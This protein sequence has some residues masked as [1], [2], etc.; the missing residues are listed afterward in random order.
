MPGLGNQNATKR[1]GMV[2]G[3]VCNLQRVACHDRQFCPA[4]FCKPGPQGDRIHL[5]IR[6]PETRRDDNLSIARCRNVGM[7]P[8]I[9]QPRTCNLA[10]SLGGVGCP[11]HLM[12]VHQ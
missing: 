1:I 3:Q 10:Q 12:R 6:P 2:Q 5:E 9:L 4:V 11:E 7:M 8:F